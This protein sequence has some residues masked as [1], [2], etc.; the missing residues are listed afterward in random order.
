MANDVLTLKIPPGNDV[1]FLYISLANGNRM[2]YGHVNFPKCQKCHPA[3]CQDRKW[4][5]GVP[6]MTQWLMNLTR[7]HEVAGLIPNPA[8]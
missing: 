3:M 6:I 8:Q 1:Q 7:N 2:A 5:I 4:E